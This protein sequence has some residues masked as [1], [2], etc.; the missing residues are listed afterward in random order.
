MPRKPPLQWSRIAL[1]PLVR[2]ALRGRLEPAEADAVLDFALRDYAARRPRLPAEP[3]L[4]GRLMVRLAALTVGVYRALSDAGLSPEEARDLTARVTGSAYRRMAAVPGALSAMLAGDPVD[5]VRRATRTFRR[6]PFGPPAYRMEDVP[7][8]ERTV[9]FDVLRC[10]AADY[11]RSQGLGP[12][13]QAAWCDLD[14]PLARAWGTRLER[15]TTLA[16][17]GARCDFRWR[18][19]SE[20]HEEET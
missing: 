12:L 14:Y 19:R 5:R 1:R 8:D 15:T 6:F 17:G 18:V 9:A 2:E 4:N 13:C 16:G 10:P 7:A 20:D 3:G 11:F